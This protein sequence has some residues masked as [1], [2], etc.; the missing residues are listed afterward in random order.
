MWAGVETVALQV[1]VQAGA[2]D[3]H[4]LRCAQAVAVAHLKGF[5]N[6]HLADFVQRER[7]PI[8]VAGD[9]RRTMLQLLRQVADVNE[10]ASGG[11]A[12]GRDDVFE[13]ADVAGSGM[14][15]QNGLG[16]AREPGDI[17]AIVCT[18][19]RGWLDR[20]HE[21]DGAY[22][23]HASERDVL[24]RRIHPNQVR[25]ALRKRSRLHP[26]RKLPPSHFASVLAS[27]RST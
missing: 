20:T 24:P 17:L 2:A 12:G 25:L 9:P 21:D 10:I 13:F 8:L 6:V 3:A 19:G 26:N 16:A 11:D 7:A 14:L 4:N 5:L 15:Q 22:R 23:K 18:L 27:P 1:A